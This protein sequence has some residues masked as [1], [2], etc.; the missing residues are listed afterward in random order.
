MLPGSWGGPLVRAGRPRPAVRSKS[1]A[2]ASPRIA[3]PGGLARTRASAPLAL[4]CRPCPRAAPAIPCLRPHSPSFS[5]SRPSLSFVSS[6]GRSGRIRTLGLR[7]WRPP[8]Y[9]LS[10]TPLCRVSGKPFGRPRPA[11][12]NY[13]VRPFGLLISTFSFGPTPYFIIFATTPEPTVRP[14]SRMAKRSFSSIAIGTISSTSIET[15]SPG[16]T[17]SVPS[18]SCTIPVTSVVRK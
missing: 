11:D 8:L 9:Q 10:Y 3:G 12:S 17:I 4:T 6:T 18:G 1:Q 14:P 5:L 16:I 2:L 7:F 13:S 15:L